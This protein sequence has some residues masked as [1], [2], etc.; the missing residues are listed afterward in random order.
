MLRSTSG[1]HRGKVEGKDDLEVE[2]AS[3]MDRMV[4]LRWSY[5]KN[6][7]LT[8]QGGDLLLFSKGY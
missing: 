8:K 4:Q 2:F 6:L 5:G 3:R 7:Q 1:M